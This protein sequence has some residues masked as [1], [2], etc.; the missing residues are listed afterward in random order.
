MLAPMQGKRQLKEYQRFPDE[1]R[2]F[3]DKEDE[4]VK[5]KEITLYGFQACFDTCTLSLINAKSPEIC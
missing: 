4:F 1:H 5:H 2:L 3:L